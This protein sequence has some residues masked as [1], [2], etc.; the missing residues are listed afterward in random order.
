ME[1]K[2]KLKMSLK[3]YSAITIPVMAF[4][5]VF[6][7]VLT[8]VTNY[9]TPALDAFLGKGSR[10]AT[11]SSGTSGWDSDYYTF[12]AKNS[13]EALMNSAKVAEAIADEGE[14]LLK[15]DGLL[16]LSEDAA[17]TPMGY[18]YLTPLM[19]GSGSGSTNTSADYVYS[20]V[21]GIQ[22]AFSNVNNA[23]SAILF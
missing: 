6:A 1:K 9:F 22:E 20:A 14:V 7:I 19:S 2:Q 15:N 10:S 4:F 8:T 3:M 12:A 21:R 5:M 13:E 23:A 11:V 18:R 16:P 17:V